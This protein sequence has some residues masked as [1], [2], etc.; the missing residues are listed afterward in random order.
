MFFTFIRLQLLLFEHH[1]YIIGPISSISGCL[2]V[3]LQSSS[4]CVYIPWLSICDI[5][6]AISQNKPCVHAVIYL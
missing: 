2:T 6:M 4:Q 1:K 5:Q 3:A